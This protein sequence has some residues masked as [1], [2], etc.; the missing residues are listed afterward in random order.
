MTDDRQLLRG[1]AGPDH[2]G[3]PLAV[4]GSAT[5]TRDDSTDVRINVHAAK[6]SVLV[7]SDTYHP[8]WTATIDGRPTQ[9]GRVD[10]VVRGVVVPTRSSTVVFTYRSTARN[11]AEDLS[12]AHPPRTARRLRVSAF[13]RAAVT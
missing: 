3:R 11:L 6:P 10:S 5:I 13:K 2:V 1:D 12:V 8:N 4:T 9:V 7:L